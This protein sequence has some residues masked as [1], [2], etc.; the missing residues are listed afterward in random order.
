MIWDEIYSRENTKLN[1][2]A[3]LDVQSNNGVLDSH[4][5][6][7]ISAFAVSMV[8]N[9]RSSL[10]ATEN[11]TACLQR[12]L[13]FPD[14][15]NLVKLIAKAKSLQALALDSNVNSLHIQHNLYS[16]RKSVVTRGHSL[17][18]DLSSP[19]TPWKMVHESYWEEKWRV[20]HDEEESQKKMTRKNKL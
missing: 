18:L 12:L 2:A 17:S 19:R 8:L 11:A 9:L 10:L 1:K 16:S 7:F 3:G 15:I 14:D 20:L 6:A 4:R 13:N 5:G